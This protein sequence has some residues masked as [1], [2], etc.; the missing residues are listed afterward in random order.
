MENYYQSDQYKESLKQQ[1]D[2]KEELRRYITSHITLQGFT[3]KMNSI[4]T[5]R[6]R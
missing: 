2:A 5:D 4:S 3:F 6:Y 1:K